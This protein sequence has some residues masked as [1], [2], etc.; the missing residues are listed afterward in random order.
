PDTSSIW[1]TGC[2]PP[3]RS[4]TCRRS[5]GTC[6]STLDDDWCS[7]D[8]TWHSVL[9]GR[10]ARISPPGAGRAAAVAGAHRR[11]ATQL[12]GDWRKISTDRAHVQARRGALEPPWT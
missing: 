3:H 12:R 1:D 10:D 9:D 6:T 8:G 4:N 2:C 7:P 11:D 5:H